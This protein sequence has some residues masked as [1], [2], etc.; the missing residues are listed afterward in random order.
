MEV[1]PASNTTQEMNRKLQEYFVAGTQLVWYVAPEMQRITVYTTPEQG[2]ELGVEDVLDGGMCCPVFNYEFA[3]C[4]TVPAGVDHHSEGRPVFLISIPL[5]RF[6]IGAQYRIHAS[7]VSSSLFF[8]P[9]HQVTVETQRDGLF[10]GRHPDFRIFPKILCGR[11]GIRIGQGR[12]MNLFFGHVFQ[13]FH[14][15][16]RVFRKFLSGI[17]DNM[18]VFH[19]CLPFSL[20]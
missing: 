11:L 3:S 7:L 17:S 5:T 10:W 4:L 8:K 9:R 15:S 20:I 19:V 18:L 12:C 16:F 2:V 13:A 1:L 6:H 14:I